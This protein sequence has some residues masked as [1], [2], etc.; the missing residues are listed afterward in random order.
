MRDIT[1]PNRA[2]LAFPSCR[3]CPSRCPQETLGRTRPAATQYAGR[4]RLSRS[5]EA[6]S[7]DILGG[8]ADPPSSGLRHV[9]DDPQPL[10]DNAGRPAS[11][12][13]LRRRWALRLGIPRELV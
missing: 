1:Y 3:R 6:G 12:L 5:A 4:G 13:R 11:G 9:L 10:T 7:F 2:F 8:L